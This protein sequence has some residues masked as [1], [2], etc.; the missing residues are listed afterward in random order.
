MLVKKRWRYGIIYISAAYFLIGN[1]RKEL[2]K[3]L[4]K[5]IPRQARSLQ[6]FLELSQKKIGLY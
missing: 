2:G 1:S 6:F 4:T 5:K 3:T